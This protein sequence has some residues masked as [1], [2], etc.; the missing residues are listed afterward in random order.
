MFKTKLSAI[1]VAVVICA[2]SAQLHGAD[3]LDAPLLRSGGMG[4]RD[5]NDVYAF[6]SPANPDNTVLILTVN[7]FIGTASSAAF[8]DDVDYQFQIDNNG[9]S[10]ADITYS[11]TFT[12]GALQ[13][14]TFTTTKNSAAFA[15]GGTGTDV[16]T[17]GGGTIHAGQFDDPFFFDLAGFQNGFA[18]TGVDAFAGANVSAIVLE[19]PSVELG[20][21]NIGVW[22]RTTVGGQQIDRMGRPAHQYR[23]HSRKP[24]R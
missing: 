14:Q 15:S 18:F 1:A 10:I 17:T 12:A 2:S 8:G 7:P 9:D 5:I 19:V 16:S 24:E 4:N 21:P 11:T 3:H 6:Q 20:G 23:A 13:N 22:A